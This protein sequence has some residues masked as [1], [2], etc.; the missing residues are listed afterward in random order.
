MQKSGEKVHTKLPQNHRDEL[1]PITPPPMGKNTRRELS[2]VGKG[3][4]IALF[5]FFLS[6]I[7]I[8]L[9]L[10]PLQAVLGR[11]SKI[12]FGGLQNAVMSR[13]SL[14]LG[15]PKNLPNANCGPS[16][17]RLGVIESLPESNYVT[18]EHLMCG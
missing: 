10:V 18:N 12:S 5:W 6:K 17:E 2:L 1:L 13:T 4:A 8:V 14:D 11:P 7:S 15:D 9:L 3:M 16:S